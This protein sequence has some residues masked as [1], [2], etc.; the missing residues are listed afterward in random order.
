MRGGIIGGLSARILGAH[1]RAWGG[2]K[3]VSR[4][5]PTASWGLN[6]QN[7]NF[8]VSYRT[9]VYSFPGLKWICKTT[10]N[11]RNRPYIAR[12]TNT[13]RTTMASYPHENI[14]TRVSRGPGVYGMGIHAQNPT[15]IPIWGWRSCAILHNPRGYIVYNFHVPRSHGPWHQFCS[16]L[17]ARRHR[18]AP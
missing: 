9:L 7:P 14:S 17:R 11:P 4:S 5:W 12:K 6:G 16:A 8:G 3:K 2:E 15:H 10:R 1:S 13:Q 18:G